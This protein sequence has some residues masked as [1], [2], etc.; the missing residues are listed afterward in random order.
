MRT[1]IGLA[2]AAVVA[3]AA[4]Q[5]FAPRE[6]PPLAASRLPVERMH[7]NT[8]VATKAGLVTAGELGHLL[9]SSNQ[10]G[11]WQRASVDQ[12]RKA[13]LN[14]VAFAADGMTGMAVGHEGWILR[15]S[16]GGWSWSEAAFDAKNGEPLMSVAKLPTGRWIAVGA[17]GRA[18]QSEDGGRTWSPLHLP[19]AGVEDKHLNRI[20]GSPDGQRW[21]IVG[22]RGLVLRSND[23]GTTWA[24]VEPFYNG[25]FYNAVALRSGGW[26]VYGMRGHIYRAASEMAA[27]QRVEVGAPV[28]FFSHAQTGDGALH[29]VGQGGMVATSRDDG[30]SFALARTG[31]RATLT[32]LHLQP[33]G[34]GWLTSDAGIKPYPPVPPNAGLSTPGTAR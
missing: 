30:A 2:M 12:D 32:D 15:S 26:L 8:L 33:D 10:G 9:V 21:L 3:L 27:W 4:A 11:S 29:L 25:S 6:T 31:G 7:M 16:D 24:V 19:E 22:E 28:S 13:L 5:A 34:R 23:Q 20:V 1:P 14:Q 18:L 17:F